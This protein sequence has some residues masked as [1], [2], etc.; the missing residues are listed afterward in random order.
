[1]TPRLHLVTLGVQD[2][3][4]AAA[5]YKALGWEPEPASSE[6][7]VFFD[8]GCLALALYERG[9]LAKDARTDPAGAGFRAVTLA[10]N[11]DSPLAVDRTLD[12]AVAAGATLVKAGQEVFWGGYSGYFADPDGHLWEVAH[13]PFFALDAEGFLRLAQGGD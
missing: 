13:N 2:L 3:A 12:E 7:I 9:A 10:H 4:R 1:M 11:V 5:F 6:A 8:L